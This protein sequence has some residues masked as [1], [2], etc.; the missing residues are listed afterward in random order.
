MAMWFYSINGT[1]QGPVEDDEMRAMLASR[2]IQPSTLIWREGME[3]WQPLGRHPEWMSQI[4]SPVGPPIPGYGNVAPTNGLSVASMVCGLVSLP[5]MLGCWV[6]II[7]A[8]PA[9]ICGHMALSQLQ[10]NPSQE[11][12]GFAITG[13]IAGYLTILITIIL[14]V[15]FGVVIARDM[16]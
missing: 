2:M 5:M 7:A 16:N 6:G 9:V 1:Q 10:R 14:V 8:I 15:V 3:S 12:R 11:G 4:A 13:L